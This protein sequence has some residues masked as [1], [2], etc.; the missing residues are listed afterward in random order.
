MIK[1]SSS[2]ASKKNTPS[3]SLFKGKFFEQRALSNIQYNSVYE[4]LDELTVQGYTAMQIEEMLKLGEVE[5][6]KR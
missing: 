3:R 6:N 2:G 1:K 5:F 4:A